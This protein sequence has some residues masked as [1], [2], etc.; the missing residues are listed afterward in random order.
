MTAVV[1]GTITALCGIAGVAAGLRRR[2]ARQRPSRG[3]QLRRVAAAG[4]WLGPDV[5]AAGIGWERAQRQAATAAAVG[6]TAGLAVAL[7]VARGVA[8]TVLDAAAMAAAGAAGG[9]AVTVARVRRRADRR[10]RAAVRAV[11]SYL[12]LVVM[13]LA[14]GMGVESALHAA[15]GV[16]D[17]D[18]TTQLAARL[19]VARHDGRPPW[20]VL[21]ELGAE[22]GVGELTEVAGAVSLAGTEGARIRAT[23]TAKAESVRRRQ[24]AAMESEA[25]AMTERLFVPGALL[26][27]GFLV[28]LGYPAL[29]RVL[30]GL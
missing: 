3:E 15:A 16:P 27:V 12:D 20:A 11:G 18:L 19:D 23:L 26:L 28:F 22:L 29:V 9:A 17:D 1:V 13:C 2:L 4:R 6:A 7:L 8:G 5:E 21:A 30:A 24:I 10:R 14:G 25:N